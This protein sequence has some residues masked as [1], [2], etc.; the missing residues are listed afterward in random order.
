MVAKNKKIGI[1]YT[2]KRIR[3][4]SFLVFIRKI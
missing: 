1:L 3:K 4:G 2:K